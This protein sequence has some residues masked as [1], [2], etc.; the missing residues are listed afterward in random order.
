MIGAWNAVVAA[1]TDIAEQYRDAF[2]LGREVWDCWPHAAQMTGRR[3]HRIVV[4]RP[5][6]RTTP[7]E[8]A[9][10]ENIV[11]NYWR[12]RLEQGGTIKIL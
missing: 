2:N 10:F 1:T 11:Y 5:H 7:A 4:I 6:W 8:I 3:Y 9:A 12:L